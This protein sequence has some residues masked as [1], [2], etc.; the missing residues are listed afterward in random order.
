MY[1]DNYS[2]PKNGRVGKVPRV[3]RIS[4]DHQDE[5]SLGDHEALCR[6]RLD[7][8]PKNHRTVKVVGFSRISTSHQDELSRS[9]QEAL[10]RE[11]LGRVLPEGSKF[12][13]IV[14]GDNESQ[15]GDS[16]VI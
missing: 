12:K 6:E 1:F 4:T 10:S 9:N 7:S 13:F 11:H 16:N 15:E 2:R 3:G 14:N 5:R 8:R